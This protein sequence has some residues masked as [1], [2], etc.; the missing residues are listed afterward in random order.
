[1]SDLFHARVPFEFVERV[2]DVMERTPQHTYQILTKRPDRMARFSWRL[3]KLPNVWLGTSIED[4]ERV[5][6]LAD[7]RWSQAE[8][9]FISAEPLLGPLDLG[10]RTPV[11]GLDWVIV[12][13]ESGPYARPCEPA[14]VRSL[15]DQ[16]QEV[17]VAFF[18]KQLGGRGDKRGHEKA[19]LDGRRWLEMPQPHLSRRHS[20]HLAGRRRDGAP[21]SGGLSGG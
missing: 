4:Q 17:G 1:M 16:C 7:L 3:P 20:S 6:R 2:W 12:G 15:R 18:L 10:L 11:P 5:S 9:R 21:T 8:V 13:G 14:W 19:L